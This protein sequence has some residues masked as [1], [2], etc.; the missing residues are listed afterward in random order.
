MKK[1]TTHLWLDTEAKKASEFY[2]SLFD[3]SKIE[4]IDMITDTP[5]GDCDIVTFSLA[6]QPFMAISAGPI[7]KFNPSISISVQCETE[8]EINKLHASL[9]EG[10]MD[11]MPLDTYEFSKKFAW[12][13][14]RYGLSWQINV[15]N[16]YSDVKQKI[17]PFLMFVGSECG[18]AEEAMKFYTGIFENSSIDHVYRNEKDGEKGMVDHAEFTLGGQV[19]MISDSAYDHKFAFNEA[20][21]F[22]VN[23]EDQKEVDYFWSKLSAV[24]ESEQCGWCKDQY[25]VSWQIV[26]KQMG[27]LMSRGTP[28]QAKRV[29]QAMLQMHK[30][31]VDKLQE[32][33]DGK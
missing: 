8:E 9:K 18:N 3:N 30:I 33:F 22:I 24:P 27:E 25:G 13:Q 32:A 19:F 21:S 15:P 6:E 11:L 7:F 17:S 4:H 28:E 14:D 23:C 1:I 12:V 26:P 31:E 10:G 5:S 2:T 16:N 20:I 29:T